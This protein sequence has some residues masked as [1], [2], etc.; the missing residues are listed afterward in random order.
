MA[1]VAVRAS[2]SA[3][4]T[5]TGT[6][7]TFTF[8]GTPQVG[9][10]I[11]I[12]LTDDTSGHTISAPTGWT[13]EYSVNVGTGARSFLHKKYASTDGTGVAVTFSNSSNIAYVIV[14]VD[15]SVHADFGALGTIT[16]RGASSTTASALAT[17][18][19]A[20]PNLV[21]FH[22]KSTAKAS[23]PT[24]A[25][26]TTT[27]RSQW[28]AQP[29][30][31][32]VGSYDTT[33]GTADRTA[34]YPVST[35]NA[36]GYQVPVTL[37]AASSYAFATP[38][39]GSGA[40]PAPAATS[41][42]VVPATP[43]VGSGSMPDAA[44][45]QGQ[46]VSTTPAL[47]SGSMPAP[48]AYTG[49]GNRLYVVGSSSR[50]SAVAPVPPMLGAGLMPD[51]ATR[52][53]QVAAATPMLGSGLMPD[54][55]VATPGT[56]NRLFVMGS[57]AGTVAVITA[58]PMLGAGLM[59]DPQPVTPGAGNRLRIFGSESQ[60]VLPANKL[61][62]LG[63]RLTL[64][65]GSNALRILGSWSATAFRANKL[66]ILGSRGGVDDG[67]SLVS[68]LAVGVEPFDSV[69][70][71]AAP[72]AGYGVTW[73]VLDE[74]PATVTVLTPTTC[75]VTP[76]LNTGKDPVQVQ[77][78]VTATSGGSVRTAVSVLTVW[79]VAFYRVQD[80]LSVRPE[81]RYVVT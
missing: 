69:V 22:E 72:P 75:R 35:A 24:V 28:T 38:A 12:W 57:R 23:G 77:V 2:S 34:T 42:Q 80:D 13:L 79:A 54:A 8:P 19:S 30:S 39:L 27:I 29:P 81:P 41:G 15:G 43:A 10:P 60:T 66:L 47:G 71:T 6:P 3:Y 50:I 68:P 56:G 48:A 36:A 65:G 53:G 49:T 58:P 9:D 40:M 20:V 73:T 67:T 17:G 37:V 26:T 51:P 61:L 45:L 62:I 25:P 59:P 44:A 46:V 16:S 74:D 76:A 1:D 21:V 64:T 33:G 78:Q 14:V 5:G 31:M 11:G 55:S 52:Q 18:S 7:F 32:F 4:Q 63:S 70:L